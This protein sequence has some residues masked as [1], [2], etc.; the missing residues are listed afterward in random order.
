MSVTDGSSFQDSTIPSTMNIESASRYTSEGTCE[1]TNNLARSRSSF[2]LV[3]KF[4]KMRRMKSMPTHLPY[5]FVIAKRTI[6]FRISDVG[7]ERGA[8]S[9]ASLRTI[10]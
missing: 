7:M 1:S 3:E 10:G 9:T 4:P 5:F 2:E 8:P 6:Q